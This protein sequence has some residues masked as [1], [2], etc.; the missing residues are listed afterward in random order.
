MTDNEKETK[1]CPYCAE[2]IKEE[3]IKCKHC[4]SQIEKDIKNLKAS[5]HESYA[6]FTLLALILPLIGLILGAVYL[7]KD[8]KL[9]KKLGEHT[10]AISILFM[11]IWP[12]V[13]YLFFI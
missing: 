6:T 4:G 9:D 13:W 7:S 11:I 2:K 1:I 12:I 8:N 5:Q 3:A 10:L